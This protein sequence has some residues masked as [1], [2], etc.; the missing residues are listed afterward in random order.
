M[1]IDLKTFQKSLAQHKVYDAWQYIESLRE[2][3]TY[4]NISCELLEKVYA[5]RLKALSALEQKTMETAVKT[6]KS[7]IREEDL[8]CTNLDIAGLIIDDSIFLPKNTIEFFHYARISMDVLFQII[9]AA[10]FG[11]QSIKVT[12][13]KLILNV[14]NKLRETPAFTD[15]NTLLNNK[16]V[17]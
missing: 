17:P 7:S 14:L 13:K 10:L 9:N 8:H 1:N 15:L 3:L 11:D 16:K 6:G 4:M 5:H 2:T 12:D